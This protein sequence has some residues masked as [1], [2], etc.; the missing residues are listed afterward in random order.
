MACIM[1]AATIREVRLDQGERFPVLERG[2]MS[3]AQAAMVDAILAG[4]R[5]SVRGP[6]NTWLRSPELGDRL[7]RVG[8]YLRYDSALPWALREFAILITAA[9]WRCELEWHIHHAD[10]LTAGL[11]DGLAQDLLAGRR[12]AGMDTATAL[13]YDFA[14]QLHGTHAVDDSVFAAA[15]AQFGEAGVT[16]LIGLLGYYTTVAMTLNVARAALPDGAR[17]VFGA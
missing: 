2:A 7:Q 9:F 4:P 6:F 11:A 3:P 14:T 8:A 13:I 5:R 10:G 1:G 12:P 15:T 17:P 16:D